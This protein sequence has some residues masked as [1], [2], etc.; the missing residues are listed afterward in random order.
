MFIQSKDQ[1]IQHKKASKDIM[2]IFFS[3]FLSFFFLCLCPV[4]IPEISY[5]GMV[6]KASD[7]MGFKKIDLQIAIND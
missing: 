5:H 6:L 3:F 4:N 1:D 2:I 7:R